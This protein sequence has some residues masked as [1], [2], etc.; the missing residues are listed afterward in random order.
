MRYL[1]ETEDN[2]L[3]ELLTAENLSAFFSIAGLAAFIVS[4]LLKGKDMR[5]ILLINSIGNL[6][7]IIS[8]L[9]VKN[10]TGALSST[11][12]MAVAVINYFYAA[13]QKKIPVWLLIVYAAAFISC[14]L[15]VWTSWVDIFAVAACL[16]AVFMICAKSGMGYRIWSIAND[17]LWTVFDV[18]RGSYGPLL[19]HGVLSG[20][21][22]L[23]LI[24]YDIKKKK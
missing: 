18:L 2:V 21:S 24:L 16:A 15:L 13:K 19:T 20:F 23:G 4:F 8:Y 9:W 6:L 5:A 17:G 11:V 3:T 14:N 1:T 22:L 12:G 10:A 7:M